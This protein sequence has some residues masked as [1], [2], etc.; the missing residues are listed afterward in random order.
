MLNEM[1]TAVDEGKNRRH[2]SIP[3]EVLLWLLSAALVILLGQ[4]VVQKSG[5]QKEP[6]VNKC[7][8]SVTTRMPT[9]RSIMRVDRY[10]TKPVL[11]TTW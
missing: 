3:A 1:L 5:L 7:F 9:D 10:A 8:G 4:I 6:V 11:C 2:G